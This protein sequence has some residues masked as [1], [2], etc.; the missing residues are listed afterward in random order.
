MHIMES[1]FVAKVIGF[2][3]TSIND[4]YLHNLI[5][6]SEL[7]VFDVTVFFILLLQLGL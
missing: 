4:N 5:D 2:I 1:S 7:L 3:A 6:M